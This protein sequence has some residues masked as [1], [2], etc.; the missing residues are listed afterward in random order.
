MSKLFSEAKNKTFTYWKTKPVMTMTEKTYSSCQISSNFNKNNKLTMLPIGY[1]WKTIDVCDDTQMKLVCDFLTENYKRGT[2]STYI[3]EFNSDKLRWEMNNNGY[4]LCVI[5]E[6]NN[7]KKDNDEK[8]CDDI[9]GAIGFTY[10]TVQIYNNKITATEPIY[11]CCKKEYRHKGISK[12]LID[13]T[14]RQSNMHGINNGIFCTNK[15]VPKPVATIRQYSRPLNYKKLRENDFIS[16]AGVDDD[17]VHNK[18]KIALRPNKKYTIAKNTP[19]NVNIAYEL[20]KEY[21]KTFNLHMVMTPNDIENYFFNEKYARTLFILDDKDVPVDFVTYNFYDIVNTEKSEN[22]VI[23]A[24]NFL[25][26]T[27][28]KTRADLIF[29]NTLKQMAEDKM[30]IVYIN[31]MMHS[32]EII[33]SSLRDSCEDTDDE[34]ADAVYDNN[35]VKTMKKTYI[36]MYNWK[37]NSLK[38]NMVSWLLF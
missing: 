7:T 15:I 14:V 34:E 37:C 23:K 6:K 35:I 18:T 33:L 1:K 2:E 11:M 36:N 27:S 28:N 21:M 12:V 16:I 22:N 26:Y 3:T 5:S 31:D 30:H 8:D 32:N 24:C 29:I 9:I 17:S 4:F 20:Y 19:N 13:E 38:Q 25:M 10:R